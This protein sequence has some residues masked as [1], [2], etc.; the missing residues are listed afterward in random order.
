MKPLGDEPEK[1]CALCPRLVTYRRLLQKENPYGFNAP[2]PPFGPVDAHIAI[3]GLAP[4]RKGANHTGRAFTGDHAGD[5]LFSALKKIGWAKGEYDRQKDDGF[6]L[7]K[8]RIVNALRCVPPA[9][10]PLSEELHRC[11]FFLEKAL[12]AMPN[13]CI[14][15]ALGRIAHEA[16]LRVH[17]IK[18]SS[19]PFAHG[20]VHIL[21]DK[22]VL[23]DSYHCSLYNTATKRLTPSMFEMVLSDI[24][25]SM[26]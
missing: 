10:K 1:D 5:F 2:V 16:V 11:R 7:V 20:R 24:E 8:C 19:F 9:N 25:E 21:P 15:L 12:V 4:G 6:H 17:G 3:I 18:L 13:L 14:I 26:K 22:K 23:F